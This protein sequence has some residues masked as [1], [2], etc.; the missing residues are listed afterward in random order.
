MPPEKPVGRGREVDF[1]EVLNAIC[2]RADNGVKW[3]NLP[4]NFPA[5]QT[6][7]PYFRAWVRSGVWEDINL[8]LVKRVRQAAGREAEP[9]LTVIDSQSV[10]LGQKGGEIG[11]DGNKK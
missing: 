9:S 3:R 6:V 2:D 5:W 10:K 8:A 11:V 4:S 7:Y 1:R